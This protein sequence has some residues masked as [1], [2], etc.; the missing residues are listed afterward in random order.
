MCYLIRQQHAEAAS[1]AAA[2]APTVPHVRPRWVG[3]ATAAAIAAMALAALLA[4]TS[5]AR[6]N[7]VSSAAA[8]PVAPRADITPVSTGGDQR[9]LP[10]DD[11]VPG[12]ETAKA[13]AGNCSH[14]L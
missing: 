14:G 3:A 13:G 9:S 10:A 11:G 4:P 2:P 12:T 1:G 5:T 7:E 8:A 6:V